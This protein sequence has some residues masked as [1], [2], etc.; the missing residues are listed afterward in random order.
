MQEYQ[1]GGIVAYHLH[2]ILQLGKITESELGYA[3]IINSAGQVLRLPVQ[4]FCLKSTAS[5]DLPDFTNLLQK[6]VEFLDSLQITMHFTAPEEALAWDEY[7]ALAL[8]DD[9][10][11]RFAHYFYIRQHPEL[12]IWKKNKF[13]LR[14]TLEL[15]IY[16]EGQDQAHNRAAFLADVQLW[17]ERLLGDTDVSSPVPAQ[18]VEPVRSE[19]QAYLLSATFT[20]L[21]RMISQ[22]KP[23]LSLEDKIMRIRVYLGDISKNTDPILAESGLPVN[24]GPLTDYSLLEVSYPLAEGVEA[25]SIDDEDSKDYDDALSVCKLAKGY[26]I[27]IHIS[28]VA[29]RIAVGSSVYRDALQRVSSLYLAPGATPLL[30]QQLSSRELSLIAGE[31][32]AC[33]SFY[34]N[35]DQDYQILESQFRLETVQITRNYSYHEIDRQISQYPFETLH[36]FS[37]ALSSERGNLA[38]SRIPKDFSYYLSTDGAKIKIR[39]V[40]HNSP[41]RILVE[42]LMVLFNRKFADYAIVNG[43]SLIFRNVSQYV[44]EGEDAGNYSSQAYL[45]TKA[46]FHPGVGTSAYVHASS[47]I[48]RFTD[49]IN[50]YQLV[51]QLSGAALPFSET[52][53]QTLIPSIEARLLKQREIIQRSE[54]YWLMKLIDQDYLHIPME[55]VVIKHIKHGMMIELSQWQK[56]F[57]LQTDSY[58]RLDS[59][60]Q[61]VITQTFPEEGY[62]VGDIIS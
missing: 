11:D 19:L 16:Q 10:I 1:V 13:R 3:N 33:L 27:G 18:V 51:A 47:P 20:D 26:R 24:F 17:L 14:N 48:R 36:K 22:T 4:R 37:T 42:E 2:D 30:P 44:P 23:D 54:R 34:V 21:I 29:A 28:A 5:Y 8:L 49:L 40:N 58:A 59:E 55:A 53:Q 45:A 61:I 39:K 46:E 31:Q 6:R 32:R 25:F 56:R 38:Q 43:V 7:T 9:D 41:A 50:Q 12:F 62:A 35:I 52:D 15:Q 57:H 60:V